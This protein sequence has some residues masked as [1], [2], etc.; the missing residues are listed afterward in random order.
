MFEFLFKY[1]QAIFSRGTFVFANGWPLWLLGAAVAAAGVALGYLIW[2]KTGARNGGI[3]A[4]AVWLLQTV[5]AALLLFM[6]WHPALS[7]A[8]LRPQQ[9]IVAV[10]VDDSSSMSIQDEGSST[11][12]DKAV[13]LLDSS[14]IASL[15]DKFQVRMY[16]MSD[17][18]ERIEKSEQVTA[19]APATH[20]GDSLKEVVAD[21][22]SLP[23]GAVVLLSDGADNAGGVDLE[24]I[25]EIRRQRI[26]VHTIGFG[27]EKMSHDLELTGA[28]TAA[29]ALPDSRLS[30]AVT[31]HQHGYAGQK[32]KLNVRDG[33]KLI[34]SKDV[35][36]KGDGVEQVESVLFNAGPAAVK[37]FDISF[38][39]LSN[40]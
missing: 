3:R 1:P 20:I 2:S 34:A 35:V 6:L 33:T 14:L 32:V 22:A 28:E 5:L 23:I 21:A 16:R 12:R 25:S 11:R 4:A 8:T 17:H 38:D 10:V 7:V 9:N 39:P 19:K 15:R 30:A 18:L 31:F 29:R 26:P 37:S 40:E 36:L 27:R 24:T 13:G